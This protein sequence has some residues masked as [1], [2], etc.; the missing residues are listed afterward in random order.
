M[1]NF[2]EFVVQ[3]YVVYYLYFFI[4]KLEIDSLYSFWVK[5]NY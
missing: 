3:K 5:N 1:L 2:G 4:K